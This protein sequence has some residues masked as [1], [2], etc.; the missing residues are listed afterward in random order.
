M[1]IVGTQVHEE[2]G[3]RLGYMVEFVGEEGDV[4]SVLMRQSSDRSVSRNNAVDMAL[5]ILRQTAAFDP[6][7]LQQNGS[8]GSEQDRNR[9]LRPGDE[10]DKQQR[11]DH[12]EAV[13]EEQL[14]EGL[15]DT[16]PASD[17]VSVT[18]KVTSG[19]GPKSN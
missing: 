3:G 6:G 17:P 13:L 16:F 7:S 19:N 18:Q 8:A 2:M 4:V 14:D 9:D 12:A 5:D 10:G 15:E 11:R 1:H